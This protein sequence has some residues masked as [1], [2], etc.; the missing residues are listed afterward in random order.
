MA[1]LHVIGQI[2][3]ASGFPNNRLLCVWEAT[4]GLTEKVSSPILTDSNAFMTEI[5]RICRNKRPSRNKRPPKTVIFQRGEYTEP[6]G[7]D[8]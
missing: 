8:G 3:G 7:F 1:E 5:C 2:I 6:T 4:T